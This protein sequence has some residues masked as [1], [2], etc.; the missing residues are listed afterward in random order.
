MSRTLQAFHSERRAP[1]VSPVPREGDFARWNGTPAA[2]GTRGPAHP[3]L[4]SGIFAPGGQ[5]W[6]SECNACSVCKT[7]FDATLVALR[8]RLQCN[9]SGLKRRVPRARPCLLVCTLYDRPWQFLHGVIPLVATVQ[10]S[11]ETIEEQIGS[12]RSYAVRPRPSHATK[13]ATTSVSAHGE[14]DEQ[15]LFVRRM[16]KPRTRRHGQ[17]RG[18]RRELNI[19]AVRVMYALLPLLLYAAGTAGAKTLQ[20]LHSAAQGQRRGRSL[21]AP[22]WVPERKKSRTLQDVPFRTTSAVCV[23]RP[24]GRRFRPMEW[25]ACSVR[26]TWTRSPRAGLRDLRLRR[27]A[28]GFGMQRLQTSNAPNATGKA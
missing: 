10:E 17:A 25:N 9:V 22:P 14:Q 1:C 18:T 4:A 3:G 12:T 20:A 15:S 7:I 8:S 27:P 16:S 11:S 21:G 6:A 5:P 24:S 23:T 19:H 13:Q 28:L 2:F 26:E